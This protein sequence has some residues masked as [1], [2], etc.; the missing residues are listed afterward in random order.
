MSIHKIGSDLIRPSGPKGPRGGPV[1]SDQA[2]TE[3]VRRVDRA[4]RVDI[5]NEGREMAARLASEAEGVSESREK[6]IE[7]RIGTR[8]YN[9]PSVAAVVADRLL[10]S[11]DLGIHP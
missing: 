10:S 2:E 3:E 9:E 6:K 11:G 5:S 7:H 1:S 8:F 4:D